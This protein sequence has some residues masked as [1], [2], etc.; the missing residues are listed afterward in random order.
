MSITKPVQP[1]R[2]HI[3]SADIRC[4]ARHWNVTEKRL[5]LTIDKTGNS[6][7]AVRKELAIDETVKAQ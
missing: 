3:R 1:E 7:V 4:W 2:N 6:V 5:R